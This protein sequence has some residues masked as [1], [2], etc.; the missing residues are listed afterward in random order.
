[1]SIFSIYRAEYRAIS[2]DIDVDF[3][4]SMSIFEFET[5]NDVGFFRYPEFYFFD[6]DVDVNIEKKNSIFSGFDVVDVRY[7]TFKFD[8]D[9]SIFDVC[10]EIRYN[11]L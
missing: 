8:F 10:F 1:M 5:S 9:I 11:K 3:S 4:S 6:V 7:P 2:F